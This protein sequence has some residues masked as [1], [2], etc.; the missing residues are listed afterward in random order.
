LLTQKPDCSGN[1]PK[2]S[3]KPI[4]CS[5]ANKFT[6]KRSYALLNKK[7]SLILDAEIHKNLK[8]GNDEK[9]NEC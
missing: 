7:I 3:L 9:K 8:P 4:K 2:I 5:H 6:I 1:V